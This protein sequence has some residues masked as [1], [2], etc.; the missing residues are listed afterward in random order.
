MVV[1]MSDFAARA[2]PGRA[3]FS[4]LADD[5][6]ARYLVAIAALAGLYYAAA[7]IG[8]QLKF[9]GAVAAI[10]WLPVGVGISFLY[11]G[12]LRLWPGVLAGDLIANQYQ[13]LPVGSAIGQSIGNV[14]EVVIATALLRRLTKGRPL[15]SVAGV[16]GVLIA[17]CVGTAESATV[18]PL[19]LRLGGVITTADLPHVWHTWWLG[20][21]AGALIVVPFALA[22]W[23]PLRFRWDSGRVLEGSILL[24]AIMVLTELA[25]R[26]DR[27][28]SYIVFPAFTWAALRFGTR[29]ATFAVAF[30]AG[31]TLWKTAHHAGPFV[32]SSLPR[33]TLSTQLYVVVASVST[34]FL[35]AVVSERAAIAR[36]LAES[37]TRLVEVGDRERRRLEQN[38]HD[39]AQLTLTLLAGQLAAA[40]GN[41][42]RA[43]EQASAVFE[44][45]E[46]QVLTAIDQLRELAHGIHPTVLTDLGLADA[47]RSFTVGSPVPI[48]LLELPPRRAGAGAE[49]AAYYVI[50]E[51]VT[52]AQ[53][54][55]R[56]GAITIRVSRSNRALHVEVADDGVGG[57][58]AR[59]SGLQGVRDRVEAAGGAFDVATAPGWGTRVRAL[60]PT[61][62]GVAPGF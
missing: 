12:G 30:A 19:S 17:V 43:P 1:A 36:G 54:H 24:L 46:Q 34:M 8:Y 22:W 61:T 57:A 2:A 26:S 3:R 21:T 10:V 35:A 15:E 20:D 11:F 5:G 41:T 44:A 6:R 37:R 23:R 7:Q 14:L 29:G 38:L 28:L 58:D 16:F 18:G 48:K 32:V 53:K 45:A 27:P 25:L 31:Y 59:G 52:N 40:K 13:T 42:Q 51:A 39:G 49:A 9:S 62:D 50:A 47:V 56:A 4:R 60:V 33:S 55:A